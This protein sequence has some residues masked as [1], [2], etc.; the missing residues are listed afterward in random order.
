MRPVATAT[1]AE[2]ER[3][4]GFLSG[5]APEVRRQVMIGL[6]VFHYILVLGLG[7]WYNFT[8]YTDLTAARQEV[9]GYENE[10]SMQ[11]VVTAQLNAARAELEELEIR[12]DAVYGLLPD[13]VAVPT[14]PVETQPISLQPSSSARATARLMTRSL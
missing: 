5:L 13:A 7:A 6:V 14:F 11:Q 8:L 1:A 12:R 9:A 2:R 10:L 3:P 4:R